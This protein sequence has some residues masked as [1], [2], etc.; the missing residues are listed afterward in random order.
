MSA[1]DGAFGSG[2]GLRTDWRRVHRQHFFGDAMWLSNDHMQRTRSSSISWSSIM[3]NVV[4]D[5]RVRYLK[6]PVSFM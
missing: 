6:S 4:L 2:N 1:A 3:A 5:A